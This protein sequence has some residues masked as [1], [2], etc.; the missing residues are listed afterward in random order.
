[1]AVFLFHLVSKE[2]KLDE[3]RKESQAKGTNCYKRIP[4]YLNKQ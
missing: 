2:A 1:M 4:E 3:E